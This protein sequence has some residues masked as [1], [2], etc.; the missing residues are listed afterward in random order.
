M[1][2]L[3]LATGNAGKINE[4]Q[5]LLAGLTLEMV[6][7]GGIGLHLHVDEVGSTYGQ[8]AA[9]KAR[10]YAQAT[11]LLT[12]AD[13]SGLEVSALHGLPGLRS[14]RYA[15]QPGA[16]DSD[17]RKRLLQALKPHSPPWTARFRS[18]V[19]IVAPDGTMHLAEGACM[20]EIIPEERGANGFGYDP[21]FLLPEFGRTMAELSMHEK[22]KVSH[23]ARALRAVLPTLA[24]LA[25]SPD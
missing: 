15:L 7:P 5:A 13:D 14:A 19:A 10:A 6:I 25:S 2:K 20:G 17:R 12:L 22:N 4:I 11:N 24:V 23:R 1:K 9:L 16:S 21:I 3:V 18:V 8:N